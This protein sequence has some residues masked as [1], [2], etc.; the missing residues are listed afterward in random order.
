MRTHTPPLSDPTIPHPTKQRCPA[1]VLKSLTLID[2]PGVLSG[3]KQQAR[4][5]DFRAVTKVVERRV[6]VICNA[7]LGGTTVRVCVCVCMNR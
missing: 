7:W 1:E 2:T 4:E 6:D 3:E 5:Y